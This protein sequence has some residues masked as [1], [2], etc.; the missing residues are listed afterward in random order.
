MVGAADERELVAA[1]DALAPEQEAHALAD[2]ILRRAQHQSAR[3]D[4]VEHV[5]RGGGGLRW[6]RVAREQHDRH[7]ERGD[8]Q[9]AGA[10]TSHGVV[11]R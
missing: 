5:S 9:L 4:H 11:A 2:R 10:H 6:R 8:E 3:C 7:C 1:G